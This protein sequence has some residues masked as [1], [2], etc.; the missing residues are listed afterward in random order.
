MLAGA[1]SIQAIAALRNVCVLS[2]CDAPM[3]TTRWHG[4]SGER[5]RITSR[6]N[7]VRATR[8]GPGSAAPV[9]GGIR[10]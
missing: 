1:P 10:M 4:C 6:A 5:Q 7:G 8:Y 2:S 3:T 9:S